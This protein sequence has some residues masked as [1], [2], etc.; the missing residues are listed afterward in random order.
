[1]NESEYDKVMK[2]P[3]RE[4]RVNNE[5]LDILTKEFDLAHNVIKTL[6]TK[7][8]RLK[9]AKPLLK[10]IANGLEYETE[11]DCQML[12]F[13]SLCDERLDN[14]NA[15]HLCDDMVLAQQALAD[16]EKSDG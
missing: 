6:R 1:M 10:K 14:V 11:Y 5:Y 13:C 16:M 4:K 7:L 15:K 9:E 12:T 2:D 3:E 8:S